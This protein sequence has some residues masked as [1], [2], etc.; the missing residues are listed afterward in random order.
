MTIAIYI[1][2]CAWN[3]LHDR[4]IDLATELPSN[5]YTLYVTREV[6]IELDAIPDGGK[7]EALKAYIIANIERSSINTTSIFGFQ[8]VGSDGLPS[9]TQVYGGFGQGTF[10][11][12]ADRT[13][14]LLPEIKCQLRGKSSRKTGLSDNQADA[15]LAA[16]SFGALVLTNDKKPGPLKLAAKKCGKIVYLTEEVDKSGFTLGEYMARLQQSIE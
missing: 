10:Q 3:Y 1:D 8:T 16:R 15:S 14:Y 6:K 2:S 11:S 12:A 13:F 9:K 4:A 7:K 5:I